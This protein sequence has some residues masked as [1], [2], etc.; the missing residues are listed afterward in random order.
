[1]STASV[2]CVIVI[3]TVPQ[4]VS[5]VSTIGKP[6]LGGPWTL[7]DMHGEPKTDKDYRGQYTLLY[8]GFAFCPDICPA[9]LV[10]VCY[11][12]TLYCLSRRALIQLQ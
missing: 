2:L 8:F 3:H 11:P 1:M 10:K 9:E 7:V 4:T 12:C 6:A 5:Q